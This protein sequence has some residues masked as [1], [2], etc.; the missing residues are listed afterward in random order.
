MAPYRRA[1]TDR[2]PTEGRQTLS[3]QTIRHIAVPFYRMGAS[4]LSEL[5][6]IVTDP[7]VIAVGVS[8]SILALFVAAATNRVCVFENRADFIWTA[9]IGLIPLAWFFGL[10]VARGGEGMPLLL[11]AFDYASIKAQPGKA[12]FIA[13][14][15]AFFVVAVLNSLRSSIFNNGPIL[16]VVLFIFKL[17]SSLF[18][19]FMV[20]VTIFLE[21]G[22]KYHSRSGHHGLFYMFVGAIGYLIYLLINGERVWERREALAEL[23]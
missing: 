18:L 22:L 10:S 4:M 16:G 21:D 11:P 7:A 8:A 5:I 19:M 20:P 13:L 17:F 12:A 15:G 1:P 6:E 23:D 3:R 14:G 2:R 9:L